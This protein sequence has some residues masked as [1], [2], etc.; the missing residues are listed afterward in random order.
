MTLTP[1][2]RAQHFPTPDPHPRPAP[3][4]MGWLRVI[5]TLDPETRHQ[6]ILRITAGYEFPWDYKRSLEFALFRTYCV[7]SISELLARTG[8][9]E[10][11]PQKRYDDTALL[12][13]ELVEHGYD[14]ERG[15]DSLRNINRMHGR[16]GIS[17]DDMLYVL[18]TFVY[19]PVDWID[20]YG[21]RRLHPHERLAS[22]H[23]YRQVG[24]RMGIK[25]IPG[26]YQDFH[27]FKMDY[28]RDN[29]VYSDDNHRIGT[30]TLHLFQSWYPRVVAGPVASAVYA[31]VDDR[32]SAAFGFPSG[33]PRVKAVAEAG[34]RARSSVVRRLPKRRTSR[35]AGDPNN[36]TYPGYPVGYCPLDLGTGTH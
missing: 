9:F 31:L 3:G 24:I 23:F 15:R 20:R 17:N 18:S 8:E 30:Y 13:G 26:S 7:P 36:R 32:M 27:T 10:H 12:M 6:D 16:Y 35:G 21:W 11:R 14:S 34:L 4:R 29:F 19:D 22:Y 1:T 25:D 33:S 28:E 5:E 2:R